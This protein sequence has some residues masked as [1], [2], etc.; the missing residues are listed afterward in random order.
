M[1]EKWQ[2]NFDESNKGLHKAI[3]PVNINEFKVTLKNGQKVLFT[4]VDESLASLC[5]DAKYVNLK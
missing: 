2:I 5:Q 3:R 4:F 1:V